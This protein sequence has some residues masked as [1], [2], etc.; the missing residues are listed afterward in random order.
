MTNF[1]ADFFNDKVKDISDKIKSQSLACTSLSSVC[2]INSSLEDAGAMTLS[3]FESLSAP[4]LSEIISGMHSKT[5]ELDTLPTAILKTCLDILIMPILQIVNLSLSSSIFPDHFKHACIRP[6]LK[7]PTADQDAI[8]NYR[9]I[10]NLSFLS[11]VIEKCVYNQIMPYLMSNDLFG[12]FQSAYRPYHSCE[13]ALVAIHND[14]ETMLDSKLNVALLTFDLSAAFDTVNHHLLLK[15][16]HFQFGFCN[17]VLAW[18][19]SYLS[20]RNYYVKVNNSSYDVESMSGVPQGS[21]LGPVLF[22][23]YVRDVEQIAHQ[24]NFSIHM[25]ADDIQCYFG[26]SSDT[27]KSVVIHRIQCFVSDLKSWMNANF[28]ML[29]ELKTNFVEFAPSLKNSIK[30]IHGLNLSDNRPLSSSSSV[31]SLGVLIDDKFSLVNHINN[32]VSVCYCNLR[33]LGRIASKLCMKLKIQLIHSMILSHLD[34]CN[35]LFYG[36]P[37][38]LLNKLTKVL[39]AAVR[40]VFSFKFSQRRCHMLPFLKS[41]HILP[42]NF[43][44]KFKVALLVFKCLKSCAPKYLQQLVMLRKPSSVY[45]F[46]NNCDNFLIEKTLEPTYVKYK[47]AFSYS[48]ATVWNSLPLSVREADSIA[49]FKSQLKSYYFELAFSDVPDI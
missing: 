27:P 30:V 2:A 38:Y 37:G 20:G 46:R 11:K 5:C 15:K 7:S 34:Y 26:F 25:Y 45:H 24:H 19:D 17:N 13:T 10:S 23:L 47:S 28:L 44:V 6:L 4:D 43:R 31:K 12:V 39:Y 29:N 16:L 21:I 22:S 8:K 18:F 1:F 32:V 40:F 49:Q 3:E 35:A 41:L 14:I 48:S 36:L 33:N 42:I 9:P